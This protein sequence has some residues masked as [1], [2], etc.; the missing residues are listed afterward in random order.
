M[1]EAL[2]GRPP[3]REDALP[4]LIHRV[5]SEPVPSPQQFE[6][7]VPQGLCEVVQ[8]MLAQSPADRPQTGGEVVEELAPF[9]RG[10]TTRRSR[11]DGESS[12]SVWS[13]FVGMFSKKRGEAS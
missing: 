5:Q 4:E 9:G 11:T 10:E 12:T 2:T 1:F 3:F 6:L 13:S 7:E 8:R